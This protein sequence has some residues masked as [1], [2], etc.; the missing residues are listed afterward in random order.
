MG[1][2]TIAVL[3]SCSHCGED[4][5]ETAF[6]KDKKTMCI[7]CH[8]AYARERYA[9]NRSQV[10]AQRKRRI[11]ENPAEHAQYMRNWRLQNLYGI[12]SDEYDQLLDQQSGKCTIC[13]RPPGKRALNVDHNHETGQ[14][15]GL[16]CHGCNTALGLFGDSPDTLGTA[17]GYLRG[18]KSVI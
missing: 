9:E 12:S 5:P 3:K 15:R 17:L 18:T 7:E 14:V 4:K 13:S 1:K 16:L 2:N 6:Y 11:K 8:K 10:L